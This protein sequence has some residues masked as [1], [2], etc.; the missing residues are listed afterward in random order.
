MRYKN[1]QAR[2]ADQSK[3]KRGNTYFWKR[4]LDIALAVVG[5]GLFLPVM[6]I[7]AILVGIVMGRPVLFRQRRPG[8]HG[9]PFDILKFR[10]M[11]NGRDELGRLLPDGKRLTSLGVFLRKSSLDELPELFNILSGDMSFVGPRPLLERYIPYYTAREATRQNVRPGLT[12]LAQVSGRN[13][14]DWDKRL[15]MDAVYVERISFWLDVKI[16]AKTIKAVLFA[17]GAQANADRAETW[18]DEERAGRGGFGLQAKPP[19][20]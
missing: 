15:E 9:V 16:M 18:L 4:P 10:T 14:L 12:G 1:G 8:L 3:P 5:L 11:T 13:Q 19:T 7:I 17:T 20:G 2:A 6:G